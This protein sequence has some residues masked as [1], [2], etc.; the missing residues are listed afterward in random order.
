MYSEHRTRKSVHFQE[1][2]TVVNHL[3]RRAKTSK[4][5]LAY[6]RYLKE[7]STGHWLFNART[8]DPSFTEYMLELAGEDDPE[9][10]TDKFSVNPLSTNVAVSTT[11]HRRL[12]LRWPT[13]PS[14]I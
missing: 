9:C 7:S 1:L 3:R 13:Q 2:K 5:K 10:L 4:D 14:F 8:D 12:Q 6:L 11:I